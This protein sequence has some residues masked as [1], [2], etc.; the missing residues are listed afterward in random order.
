MNGCSDPNRR[1]SQER[2]FASRLSFSNGD[3][4][5]HAIV[6]KANGCPDNGKTW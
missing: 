3:T 1:S 6:P 5:A 4:P 2:R